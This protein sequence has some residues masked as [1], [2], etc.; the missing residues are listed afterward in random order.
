[1]QKFL[2]VALALALMPVSNANAVHIDPALEPYLGQPGSRKQLTVIAVFED[3][4]PA[5]EVRASRATYTK[6]RTHLFRNSIESQGPAIRALRERRAEFATVQNFKPLWIANAMII[7][8]NS[9]GLQNLRH[10]P[11]LKALMAD[12]KIELIQPVRRT[13]VNPRQFADKFTYGLEKLNIPAVRR[14]LPKATGEGVL[15]GV[16]DTGIDA[17]HPDLTGRLKAF[18]DFVGSKQ[19]PYD[20]HGHGTHVSGTI[21]GGGSS[22]TEIGVAP[23]TS[24]LNGKIF[25]ASGSSSLSI[26]LQGMQWMADP[27]D[28]ASTKDHPAAVSNSWG[29]GPPS[30]TADPKDDVLCKAVDG[31]LKLG[32]LPIF[33]NGNSGPRSGTVGIP[34]ACPGSLGVGATDSRD[35]I[36]SFS[37]RGPAKWKTGE[38]IKPDVSAPGVDV[39]SA[40]PNGKYAAWSG[41]SMAAPHAAGL[42]ALL[43]Q[44]KPNLAV[45]DVAAIM[46]K[47]ATDLGDKGHDNVFG[48]GRIDALQALK[49]ALRR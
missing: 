18:R 21:A 30:S 24:I 49:P 28:N 41:T 16:L 3:S 29:G 47:S 46:M 43:F 2:L 22:G 11:R 4:L 48:M 17:A 35:G 7:R 12:R 37:S 1:M 26:I 10:L 45:S 23:K 32:I 39:I 36:A 19:Q 38:I 34:A 8:T 13:P 9:S 15:M 44:A 14:D 42:A 20:D 5:P 40:L 25:S 6:M 27:D 33:A 31:W